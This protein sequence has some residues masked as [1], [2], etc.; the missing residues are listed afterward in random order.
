MWILEYHVDYRIILCIEKSTEF[1][2]GKRLVPQNKEIQI[3]GKFKNWMIKCKACR[4]A[5]N[6][7]VWQIK[8]ENSEWY[9]GDVA[10]W[11][12]GKNTALR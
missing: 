10:R 5:Q 4:V 11:S 12:D 6:S 8:R 1:S 2:E 7:A 3:F 9:H